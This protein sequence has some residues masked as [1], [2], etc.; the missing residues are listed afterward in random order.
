M[1]R[2]AMLFTLVCV[3]GLFV[4]P[5]DARS[6]RTN[7]HAETADLVY[8]AAPPFAPNVM[9]WD[10]PDGERCEVPVVNWV[11]LGQQ[12]TPQQCGGEKRERARVTLNAA[13][14]KLQPMA[15]IVEW[16]VIRNG[17]IRF[18]CTGPK[19]LV[20]TDSNLQDQIYRF[21]AKRDTDIQ[22]VNLYVTVYGWTNL[23]WHTTSRCVKAP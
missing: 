1:K 6:S 7:Y 15:L 3:L 5:V 8:D 18:R 22:A 12:F 17:K 2:T 9:T 16:Q 11:K 10:A 21:S 14:D 19:T 20:Y 23:E 4:A 13:L